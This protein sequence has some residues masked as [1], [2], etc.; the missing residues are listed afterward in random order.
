M[1]AIVIGY[2]MLK[3]AEAEYGLLL[4]FGFEVVRMLVSGTM[5]AEIGV[6]FMGY[7]QYLGLAGCTVFDKVIV[8]FSMLKMFFIL[9]E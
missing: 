9:E 3:I 5:S 8:G 6:N 4:M 2:L 7:K 1:F